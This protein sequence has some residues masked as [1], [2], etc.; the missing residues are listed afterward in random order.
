MSDLND[1]FTALEAQLTAQSE[2][3]LAALS[4][5][6]DTLGLLNTA[7]DTLNNNGA[8]NTKAL[9][10]AIG[11]TS[12]CMPCPTPSLV[13]P[14]VDTTG[15]TIDQ[16]KCKRAQAFV[17]AMHEIFSV[18]GAVTDKGLFW[19]PSIVTDAISEVITTLISGGTVPLPSFPEAVQIA[20]DLLN[21]AG[22]NFTVHAHLIDYFTPL[23]SDLVDAVYPATNA[24][25]GQTAYNGVISGSGAPGYVIALFQDSAFNALYSYYFDPASTPNLTGI[26]GT[27]CTAGTCDLRTSV[28]THINGGATQQILDWSSAYSPVSSVDGVTSDQ[29]TWATI[30]MIGWTF[31]PSVDCSIFFDPAFGPYVVGH[32]TVLTMPGHTTTV[33]VVGPA[34]TVP[35]TCNVCAP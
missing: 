10:A 3:T 33:A 24:A 23:E 30:D 31:A 20:G 22:Y 25:A 4:A 26:D 9:L 35:F 15:R 8:T 14:P 2:A 13:I 28:S 21:Y 6:A 18:F 16:D 12:P 17:A 32:G 7:L 34:G 29:L 11:L 1:K 27:L 5:I 19:N